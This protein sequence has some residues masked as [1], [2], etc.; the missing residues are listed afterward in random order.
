MH[1]EISFTQGLVIVIIPCCVVIHFWG[2]SQQALI[3]MAT[4]L[5]VIDRGISA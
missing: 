2:I 3:I 1:S 4:A 5:A